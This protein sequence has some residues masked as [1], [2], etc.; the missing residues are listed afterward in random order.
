MSQVIFSPLR[1]FVV[2]VSL[3]ILLV[4]IAGFIF[5]SLRKG[6]ADDAL[7]RYI[8]IIYGPALSLFTHMGYFLFFLQSALLIPWLLLGAMQARWTIV[9]I[10]GFVS[11]WLGIGFYMYDLF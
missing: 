3:Y 5:Y 2:A 10:F 6:A 1:R 9:S 11:S 8:N 7:Y 4:I